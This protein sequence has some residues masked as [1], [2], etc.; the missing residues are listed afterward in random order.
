MTLLNRSSNGLVSSLVVLWRAARVFGPLSRAD[1]A[2]LCRPRGEAQP[3]D[4]LSVTFATWKSL[5]M[6]VEGADDIVVVVG[7][8][9]PAQDYAELFGHGVACVFGPGTPIP[10]AAKDTLDA[11]KAKLA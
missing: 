2:A 8:V 4:I 6:F 5:E 7:G 9:I 3:S 11:I 1:L 10:K